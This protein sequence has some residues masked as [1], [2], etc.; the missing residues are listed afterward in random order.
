MFIG[1]GRGE[2]IWESPVGPPTV[3]TVNHH[4]VDASLHTSNTNVHCDT[5]TA[6]DTLTYLTKYSSNVNTGEYT[7]HT[8]KVIWHLVLLKYPM[9]SVACCGNRFRVL[10][11]QIECCGDR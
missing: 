9:A 5:S 11:G 6:L 2:G 4:A 8:K 7:T 3:S 10:W 1:G